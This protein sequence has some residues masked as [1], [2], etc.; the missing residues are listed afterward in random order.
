MTEARWLA[1]T[2]PQPRLA[3]VRNRVSARKWL[4]CTAGLAVLTGPFAPR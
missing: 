4:H 2:E 1:G 3:L